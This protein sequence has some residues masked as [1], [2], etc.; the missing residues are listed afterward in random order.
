MSSLSAA[1]FQAV[2]PPEHPVDRDLAAFQAAEDLDAEANAMAPP[3]DDDMDINTANDIATL[4]NDK[5]LDSD[6]IRN[7]A[8]AVKV[9]TSSGYK[10]QA[11]H[12]RRRCHLLSGSLG[13]NFVEFV[14]RT[15]N[16]Q[17]GD[18]IFTSIPPENMPELI[19]AWIMER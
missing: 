17:P 5:I 19:C 6:H 9:Q 4:I 3:A 18:A 11:L 16:A 12:S 7:A 2:L 1:V 10:R 15:G 8:Q 14:V 13:R